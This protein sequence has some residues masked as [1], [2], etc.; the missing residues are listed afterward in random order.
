MTNLEIHFANFDRKT[1]D[2]ETNKLLCFKV[3]ASMK[4]LGNFCLEHNYA[5]N[6]GIFCVLKMFVVMSYT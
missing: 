5:L 3:S 6:N 4:C 2:I 1:K